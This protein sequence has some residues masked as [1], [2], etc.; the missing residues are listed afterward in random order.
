MTG[1]ETGVMQLPAPEAKDGQCTPDDEKAE[2]SPHGLQ[3]ALGPAD[4]LISDVW[5]PEL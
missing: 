4:T 2:D 5:P 3:R 1:T